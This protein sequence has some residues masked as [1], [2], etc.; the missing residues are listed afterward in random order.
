MC[1]FGPTED[2]TRELVKSWP[3][4]LKLEYN[5]ARNLSISRNLGIR[6][7]AGDIVAFLDDDAIP[8]PEWLD[9]I[10]AAYADEK[11]GGVG[12]FVFDHT[13]MAF[14][15]RYGTTDRLGRAD[16]SWDRAVPEY[17]F[18]YSYNFPH[19]LGANSTFRR[20]AL[21]SVRGFDEEFDY[22][23]D[24]TDLICRI[25]DAGWSI[26]QLNN[27]FVHHKYHFQSIRDEKRVTRS[28]YSIFKNKLYY[29]LIHRHGFHSAA[30]VTRF[31]L[32]EV[33]DHQKHWDWAIS[34]GILIS[35]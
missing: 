5:S 11:V 30:E 1:R 2:G 3:D 21:V 19:L 34:E 25:V 24:E 15:W 22:F 20:S 26:R 35:R 16:Q 31:W 32:G 27:A 6:L 33:D 17:N 13:G 4:P 12:G 14:Q 9:Q 18:P 29:G 28:Y 7:A 8:E 10:L 23:L